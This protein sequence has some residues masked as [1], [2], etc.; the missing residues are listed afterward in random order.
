M[1]NALVRFTSVRSFTYAV[2]CARNVAIF[3]TFRPAGDVSVSIEDVVDQSM[4]IK[5]AT[6][7]DVYPI[8]FADYDVKLLSSGIVT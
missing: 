2:R 6:G 4:R 7:K 5:G 3:G 8:K 1:V